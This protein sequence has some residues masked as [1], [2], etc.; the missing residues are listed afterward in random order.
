MA[1]CSRAREWQAALQI[2]EGMDHWKVTKDVADVCICE[3]ECHACYAKLCQLDVAWL[4]DA[5]CY[6]AAI[7]ACASSSQWQAALTLLELMRPDVTA[8]PRMRS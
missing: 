4:E 6:T 2:L 8:E 5:V 1:A 3:F 7:S